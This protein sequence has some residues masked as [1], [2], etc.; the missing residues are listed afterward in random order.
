MKIVSLFD[1]DAQGIMWT[2]SNEKLADSFCQIQ[3]YTAS[4]GEFDAADFL[5]LHSDADGIL[6]TWGSPGIDDKVIEKM[7]SLKF[8]AH[9]AGSVKTFFSKN[10][11]NKNIRM[12]NGPHVIGTFVAEMTLA[13]ALMA[14]RKTVQY[15]YRMHFEETWRSQDLNYH[16]LFNAKVGLIGF[17]NVAKQTLT[18]FRNFTSNI[19]VYD[20]YLDDETASKFGVKKESLED[21]FKTSKVVS[22]H[23]PSIPST[24]DMIDRKLFELMQADTVFIN[25][26]R[27]SVIKTTDMMDAIKKKQQVFCMDVYDNEPLETDNE[28]RSFQ[29]VILTPHISGPTLD[30]KWQILEFVLQN[31]KNASEGKETSNEITASNYDIMA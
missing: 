29:N 2:D 7:D 8:L 11:F 24:E 15:N 13:F 22:I 6:T 20:P 17:G 31:I 19:S 26:A 27:A 10:A 16:T 12:F 28:L 5:K 30:G 1:K 4:K 18:L 21:I 9:A 25:T 3:H 23:L 14:L